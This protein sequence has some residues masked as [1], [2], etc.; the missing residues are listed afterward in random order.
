[1]YIVVVLLLY[2]VISF[3]SFHLQ[4]YSTERDQNI[5]ARGF[6]QA[7]DNIDYKFILIPLMFIFLRI[8]SIIIHILLVYIQVPPKS[9]PSWILQL[10]VYFSVS[11]IA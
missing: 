1:M 9:V 3:I 8:W 11:Y 2:I 4:F 5:S 6:W 7:M 10:L